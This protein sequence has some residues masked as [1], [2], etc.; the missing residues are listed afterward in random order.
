MPL[1]LLEF[2]ERWKASSLSERSGA[3]SH[4]NE[5]CEVLGHPQPA[6]AMQTGSTTDSVRKRGERRFSDLLNNNVARLRC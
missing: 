6:A 2:V 3:Q 4:F 5:L 1:S